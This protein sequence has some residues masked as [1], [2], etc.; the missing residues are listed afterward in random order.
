M[1]VREAIRSAAAR[2]SDSEHL[3][4]AAQMDATLLLLHTLGVGRAQLLADPD[5][6]LSPQELACYEQSIA[7]RLR[8]EPI[9]YITGQQEFYG[10]S[11]RV[12][13]AVLIPRPETEHLVEAV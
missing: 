8:Y 12:T 9:Q 6:A 1:T 2:L 5:R 10:L 4:A 11:L 7:R 3:L 13:P